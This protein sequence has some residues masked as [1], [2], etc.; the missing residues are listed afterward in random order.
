M[1]E[2]RSDCS[3]MGRVAGWAAAA[4]RAALQRGGIGGAHLVDSG[5][6]SRKWSP[7]R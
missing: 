2:R 6:L 1:Q 7:P 5:R 4:Q 3:R